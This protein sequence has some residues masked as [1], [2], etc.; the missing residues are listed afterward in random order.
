MTI[1][2]NKQKTGSNLKEYR[3]E[4]NLSIIDVAEATG[5]S[6]YSIANIE[7]GNCLISTINLVILCNYYNRSIDSTIA[8]KLTNSIEKK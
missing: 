2:I 7:K 6:R 4:N 5:I 8:Y 3:L 1:N